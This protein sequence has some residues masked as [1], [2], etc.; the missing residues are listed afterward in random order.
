[1]ARTKTKTTKKTAPVKEPQI[2][3]EEIDS[4][5]MRPQQ[6][7]KGSAGYDFF[8]SV[9]EIIKPGEMVRVSTGVICQFPDDVVLLMFTRSSNPRKRGLVLMNGVGV[10]DSSYYDTK[11][12]I[13]FEFM[14]ISNKPV[15]IR[16]G[17]KI[18][19]GV[20]LKH[21]T[22][23]NAAKPTKKRTGGFGSTGK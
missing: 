18:G 5:A 7:T 21:L 20:F 17:D 12:P 1:M 19:Q 6:S 13:M 3:F 4:L 11:M 10:I 22:A 8:S 15:T 23:D 16:P 9:L 14:N 2:L